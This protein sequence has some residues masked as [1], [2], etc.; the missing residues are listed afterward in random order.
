MSA[1][2]A[3]IVRLLSYVSCSQSSPSQLRQ[4]FS[5]LAFS[6]M[7][8]MIEL[9]RIQWRCR[10]IPQPRSGGRLGGGAGVHFLRGRNKGWA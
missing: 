10:A 8:A 7:S 6:A 3:P 9:R 2:Q 1:T 4:L 5:E